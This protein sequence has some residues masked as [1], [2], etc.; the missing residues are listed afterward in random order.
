MCLDVQAGVSFDDSLDKTAAGKSLEGS[1]VV[2]Y[3]RTVYLNVDCT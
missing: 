1:Q 2:H 3:G